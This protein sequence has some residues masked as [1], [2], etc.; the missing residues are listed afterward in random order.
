MMSNTERDEKLAAALDYAQI[1]AISVSS[2]QMLALINSRNKAETS[3][4]PYKKV[5][6]YREKVVKQ[7]NWL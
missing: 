4:D 3:K 1:E 7:Y 2:V 5:S 6:E